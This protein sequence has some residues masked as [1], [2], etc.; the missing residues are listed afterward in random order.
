MAKVYILIF[1]IG[2][3][4]IIGYG[5]KYYYD[6]TQ[7]RIAVLTKNNATLKAAVETSESS[8]AEL[9]S[10][11]KKMGA[12][13]NKLQKDLQKAENYGDELRAKLNKL[14]L[15]VE[16]L[17]DSKNL[18]GRMNGATAEI[19]RGIMEESGNTNKYDLPE[20]LQRSDP[21]SGNKDSNQNRTSNSTDS[22]KTE[23]TPVK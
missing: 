4:G 2:I 8:I 22:S 23:T 20:W 10:N 1:V 16:A 3:L 7:N 21:G 6:T 13:N 17:K 18:E 5:A 9:K 15:V 19:W 12:L 11:I 14:N